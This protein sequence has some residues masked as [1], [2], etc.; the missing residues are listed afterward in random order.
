MTLPQPPTLRCV[1]PRPHDALPILAFDAGDQ[2][3]EVI[4]SCCCTSARRELI[5]S[6]WGQLGGDMQ[7]ER[8]MLDAGCASKLPLSGCGEP[9]PSRRPRTNSI[10]SGTR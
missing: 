1:A 5:A 2:R 3:G 7:T 6:T 10:M 4:K 8:A 9:W